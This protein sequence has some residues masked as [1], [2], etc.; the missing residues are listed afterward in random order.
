MLWDIDHTLVDVG[1]LG[2]ELYA[3]AFLRVAG[4]PIEHVADMAGRTDL[5]I[6][7][8]TLRLHE[9]DPTPAFRTRFADALSS[10]FS[11][12][13]PQVRARGRALPG[14]RAALAA[15][16][17]RKELIQSVLTGNVR[18]V[19]ELKLSAFDLHSFVDFEVGAYGLDGEERSSLVGLARS[20]AAKKYGHFFEQNDTVLVGDTRRDVLAAQASGAR[21]VAVATGA[22]AR[23][24][25]ASAGADLVLCDLTDTR[26]VVEALVGPNFPRAAT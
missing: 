5:A 1:S 11:A 10:T 19:A 2:R 14:A 22:T 18:D 26:A 7:S 4:R 15:C 17:N 20:R 9:I 21:V 3:A 24:D 16:A 13:H 25:L 23:E 12:H 8:E 6:M